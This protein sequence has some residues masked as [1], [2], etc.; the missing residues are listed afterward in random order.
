MASPLARVHR[1]FDFTPMNHR[2]P[3]PQR[4]VLYCV[5]AYLAP[6]LLLQLIP[7]SD[8]PYRD[9]LWLVTL[10][11][12]Y[13]L[14]LQFGMR[15]AAAGL[16]MG[17]ALFLAI[18]FLDVLRLAGTDWRITLPCYIAYSGIALSVGWLSQLMHEFYA[19]AIDGERAAVVRELALAMRR[20]VR[21]ALAAIRGEVT[22]L[23][24]PGRIGSSA[25]RS[26]LQH[27]REL[28][29]EIA[30]SIER[31]ARVTATPVFADGPSAATPAE[32]RN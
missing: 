16:L 10:A 8:V 22:Q 19:R 12:A 15:G 3:L 32:S 5:V 26:A 29:A 23:E 14:S 2:P 21:T 30:D 4:W 20:D 31:L 27:I 1:L 13:I 11:P 6:P 7:A 28:S 17:T 25:D 24:A 18:Q 9:L